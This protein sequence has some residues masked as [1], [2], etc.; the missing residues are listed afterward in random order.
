[1]LRKA[2]ERMI[3]EVAGDPVIASRKMRCAGYVA[4]VGRRDLHRAFMEKTEEKR[5][6]G[7]PW[8]TREYNIK[9]V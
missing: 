4:R 7:R 8:R 5:A 6:F 3:Q 2:L 1:M 9:K